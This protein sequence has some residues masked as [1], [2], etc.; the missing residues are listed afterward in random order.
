[1]LDA[2]RKSRWPS[3]ARGGMSVDSTHL[4]VGSRMM[5]L[6]VKVPMTHESLRSQVLPA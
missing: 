2:L 1:M 6:S 5:S 3:F 4:N